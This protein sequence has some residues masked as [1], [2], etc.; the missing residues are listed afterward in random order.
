VTLHGRTLPEATDQRTVSLTMVAFAL[1][2]AALFVPH[3]SE[4]P[5]GDIEAGRRLFL[6]HLYELASALGTAGLSMASPR[7]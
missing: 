4:V 3:Y 7:G 6:P 5:A 2:V 1:L